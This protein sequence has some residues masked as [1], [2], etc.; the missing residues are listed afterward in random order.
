MCN[1]HRPQTEKD[2]RQ[3]CGALCLCA[4]PHPP[5]STEQPATNITQSLRH[6]AT[7][8][9]STKALF[10]HK[11]EAHIHIYTALWESACLSRIWAL[12]APR[13]TQ[14]EGSS[15]SSLSHEHSTCPLAACPRDESTVN[16]LALRRCGRGVSVNASVVVTRPAPTERETDHQ[17]RVLTLRADGPRAD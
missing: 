10:V 6:N 9:Q 8:K 13:G 4:V 7:S 2:H 16:A 1:V 12:H 14:Q 17:G 11:H 15:R 3:R 5:Q